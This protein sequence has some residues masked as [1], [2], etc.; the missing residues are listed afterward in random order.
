ML[1]SADRAL[2]LAP[3]LLG[4]DRPRRYF[5]LVQQTAESRGTG[6]LPG[7]FAVVTASKG[8]LTVTNQGSNYGL[9]EGPV[10]PPPGV[11]ADYVA[12]YADLGAFDTVAN[13]NLSPDLP[14]VA[15]VLAARWLAQ[16]GQRI[17]AVVA[18]DAQGLAAVLRGSGPLVL[19]GRSLDPDALVDYLAVGQYRDF[20]PRSASEGI[21]RTQARKDALE[22]VGVAAAERLSRGGGDAVSLVRGLAE[23]VGSGHAR[24]ASDDPALAPGLR[25]AE[26]DG[27]L[28]LGPSPVAYPVVFNS[29]GGKLDTFL[30]RSLSYTSLACDKGRR[31]SRITVRLTSDPPA[32][33]LPPYVTTGVTGGVA[34]Q[35]LT[36]RVTLEVY[37]TRGA[38]LGRAALNGKPLADDVLVPGTEAGLSVWSTLLDLPPGKERVLTLDLDEPWVAGEPR[39]PEQPLAGPLRTQVHWPS[40]R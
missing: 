36:N 31:A 11:P 21:G 4:Q 33:G 37:A 17:D 7:G 30:H 13:L 14:V 9:R 40:C 10:P 28:P 18:I 39:I 8:R 35:S 26:V 6:G 34:R 2:R 19:G 23:A 1:V 5:V 16:S 38:V 12:R 29:S 32:T 24:M 3:A 15:R 25:E 20:A 22:D 27:A